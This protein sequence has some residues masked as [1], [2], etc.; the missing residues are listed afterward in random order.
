MHSATVVFSPFLAPAS[1]LCQWRWF[2]LEE[3]DKAIK[4]H[5]QLEYNAL[6]L[7]I[8]WLENYK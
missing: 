4:S 7:V 8:V 6:S 2:Y 1:A 3:E 5:S